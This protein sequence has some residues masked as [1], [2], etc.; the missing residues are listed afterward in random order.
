[1]AKLRA[2]A[3]LLT[4]GDL[5]ESGQLDGSRFLKRALVGWPCVVQ[6]RV[7]TSTST[8]A[9]V[10]PTHRGRCDR[11]VLRG[12][13]P[14]GIFLRRGLV[15][16]TGPVLS[17]SKGWWESHPGKRGGGRGRPRRLPRWPE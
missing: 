16:V 3:R 14:T 7:R 11:I 15:S 1:M 5:S 10:G 2:R 12:R 9:R 4:P 13:A 8:F 6:H 17:F